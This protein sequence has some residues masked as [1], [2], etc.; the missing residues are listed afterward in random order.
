MKITLLGTNGWYDTENGSTTCVLVQA[1]QYDIIFDAGYGFSKID[2]YT[3]G[4]RPAYLFLSHHHLDHLIGLH[5]LPKFHFNKGLTVTGQ[6]GTRRALE[7]LLDSPF[8]VPIANHRFPV[9]VV[10]LPDIQDQLP[11]GLTALPLIHSGPCQGYRLEIDGR[12]IAYC[13]DTGYCANAVTL[14]RNADLLVCECSQA[15][16][17][18]PKEEWPH[19]NP[20]LAA[21][22]AS[23]AGARQLALIHFDPSQ[24]PTLASRKGAQEEAS[25]VFPNTIAGQDGMTFKLS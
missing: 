3:I 8:A 18:Q 17:S 11:F 14:A 13:T 22:I 5:V 9:R 7:S 12:V 25:R 16:G 21:R 4:E 24:Y 2:Q 1:S 19:L 23:E 6:P 15:P 10:D 20:S